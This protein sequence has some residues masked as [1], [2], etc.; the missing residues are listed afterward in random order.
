MLEPKIPDLFVVMN[1]DELKEAIL[2]AK[3]N[4]AKNAIVYEGI[5]YGLSING[6][7]MEEFVQETNAWFPPFTEYI[8]LPTFEDKIGILLS[9]TVWKDYH[10]DLLYKTL[11][12]EKIVYKK[13]TNCFMN[14]FEFKEY[15]ETE[16]QASL[17]EPIHSPWTAR[18]AEVVETALNTIENIQ[19]AT[20]ICNAN[21]QIVCTFSCNAGF[22]I[23]M[24]IPIAK[25]FY[26]NILHLQTS[27]GYYNVYMAEDISLDD[28]A[29]L[30]K[31]KNIMFFKKNF[32]EEDIDL[33]LYQPRNRNR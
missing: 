12:N 5:Q 7:D 2:F 9:P 8:E 6:I 1:D 24:N 22:P 29:T 21:F 27:D 17:E 32:K 23:P 26:P 28:V 30:L 33:L 11:E 25:F 10:L 4:E 3:E 14:E 18:D 16:R 31:D 19:N 13:N 15:K 20:I